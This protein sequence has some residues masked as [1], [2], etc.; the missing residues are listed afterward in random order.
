MGYIINII[1]SKYL[2][3]S[4]LKHVA[5][6]G[7]VSYMR[8]NT[9]SVPDD[10]EREHGTKLSRCP[11]ARPPAL[12]IRATEQMSTSLQRKES[13]PACRSVPVNCNVDFNIAVCMCQLE[14]FFFQLARQ[15][16][17]KCASNTEGLNISIPLSHPN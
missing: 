9:V 5:V 3:I 8:V 7:G 2:R 1:L 11:V 4:I 16:I 10:R 12:T 17:S 14:N 6:I 13:I 15:A